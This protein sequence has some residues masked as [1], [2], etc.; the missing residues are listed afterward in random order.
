M[1][2]T[3]I[4]TLIVL[5]GLSAVFAKGSKEEV[6]DLSAPVTITVWTHDD[7]NRK[8]LEA[9]LIEE[10][11]KMHPNVKVDYQIYPSGKM[12]ELLTV[13][14][15][16]GE[17]PDVFNQSQSVIRQFV[18]EGQ[19]S[20]LKPQW[21]GL[22][23]L[24]E[25]TGR[26]IDG[27]LE[28]VLLDGNV[29]G[30]PLEYTNLCV[31]LNKRLFRESGLDPERDYPR[32]WEQ[33][34]EVSTKLAKHDGDIILRRGFDFRYATYYL[35][36][37]LPMVEQLG[38]KIVSDD[39][40]TAVINDEAWLRFFN[41]M[42]EW[43]P[44]GRNLGG[45]SYVSGP[46]VFDLDDGQIVM[47]ESGLYQQSRMRTANPDFYYSDDWMI[48]PFPQWEDAKYHV[49][50]HVT[51]HYYMVNGNVSEAKQVWGWRLIDFML[52]HSVDYLEQVNLVQPTHELFESETFKAMPYSEVFKNDLEHATLTYYSGNSRAVIDKMK[53]AVEAVMLQNE[54]PESVLRTFRRQVQSLIDEE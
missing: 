37:M 35:M 24:S 46:K 33:M 15:S 9:N 27:S 34:M 40:K 36:E 47:S 30:M 23:S 5:V 7:P 16:T 11:M 43:G 29:Y 51:C 21:I 10:F 49:P 12:A 3:L 45:P 6:V 32:T 42:K 22:N 31:F 17:G 53:E 2:K 1:K 18:V 28:G 25:M 50:C 39:G 54:D 26:Y 44:N 52:S 8:V 48:I 20:A 41:Y 14:F 38:G 19:V 4:F 13:A